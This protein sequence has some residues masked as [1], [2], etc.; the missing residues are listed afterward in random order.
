MP[1]FGH[2]FYGLCLLIPI[3]YFAKD[4]FNY[5]LAFIFLA[6]NI[7]GPDIVFLFSFIPMPFHS[8]LGFLIIA[9]PLSMVY[10]YC[11]RFSM[12]KSEEGWFP[13]TLVDNG[14]RDVNW[15]NAYLATAAGG[16]SHFF[17]DQ[18]YHWEREMT[19]W[20]TLIFTHNEM[21]G[22]SGLAYHTMNPIMVIGEAIVVIVILLS[23][24]TFREGTKET[25]KVFLVATALSLLLMILIST[26]IYGGERE[27]AVIVGST[28]YTLIPLGLLFYAARDILDHPRTTPDEPKI[29]R[30]TLL[31]IVALISLLLGIFMTMYALLV[32]FM[33]DT[34]V[35][36]IGGLAVATPAQIQGLGYYYGTIAIILLVGSIGLFFK[37]KTCRYLVIMTSLYFL[38]FGFP[39]AIAFFLC[40]KEVK[41]LFEKEQ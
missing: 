27:Y 40:E 34:I 23:L 17:I 31:N 4:K 36:L 21:L 41:K 22:W 6:N 35:S 11:S 16:F 19:L 1:T 10:S 33:A 5:K 9:V 12:Q 39:I 32:I 7:Y 14:I 38:I 15:K 26:E 29:N 2:V 13:L 20:P 8:M 28:F 37:N 24:Y 18:F 3:L 25:I 30:K